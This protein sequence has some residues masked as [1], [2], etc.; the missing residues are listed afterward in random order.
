MKKL[1][2]IAILFLFSCNNTEFLN[3]KVRFKNDS[4]EIVRNDRFSEGALIQAFESGLIL[5]LFKNFF[6]FTNMNIRISMGYIL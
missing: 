5:K 4:T 2:A 6:K 1:I 3:P